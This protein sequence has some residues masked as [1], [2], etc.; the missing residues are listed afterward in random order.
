M[1]HAFLGGGHMRSTPDDEQV[2][3][4]EQREH[5]EGD[6]F[7]CEG[8]LPSTAY[9]TVLGPRFQKQGD[10]FTPG[11]LRPTL[12]STTHP[13]TA[14]RVWEF[15]GFRHLPEFFFQVTDL[16]AQTGRKFELELFG[17]GH[18]S[19]RSVG[20]SGRRGPARAGR[21]S[22][23]PRGVCLPRWDSTGTPRC[24]LPALPALR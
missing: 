8:F 7:K 12:R 6:D 2:D 16:V 5:H 23:S 10:V 3:D 14:R 24:E 18:A 21:P 19:V 13:L 17:G 9:V 22:G 1:L 15:V 20:E 4:K 11:P